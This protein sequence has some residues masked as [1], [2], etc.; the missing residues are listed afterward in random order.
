MYG[1]TYLG[2]TITYTEQLRCLHKIMAT[3]DP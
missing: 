1:A 3:C 2:D